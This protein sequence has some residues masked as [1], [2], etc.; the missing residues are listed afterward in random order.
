M[1]YVQWVHGLIHVMVCEAG[2]TKFR[3]CG[4]F[5]GAPKYDSRDI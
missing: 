5:H 4:G 2:G 3:I 1:P